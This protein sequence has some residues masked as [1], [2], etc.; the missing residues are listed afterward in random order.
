MAETAKAPA[1]QGAQILVIRGSNPVHA[2]DF[3]L[4]DF[5]HVFLFQKHLHILKYKMQGLR[6]LWGQI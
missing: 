2:R 6:N 5:F 4:R 1:S 3:F